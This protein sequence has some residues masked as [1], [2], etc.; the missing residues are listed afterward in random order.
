MSVKENLIDI[1]RKTE[2]NQINGHSVLAE[3][4]FM[5]RVFEKFADRLLSHGVVLFDDWSKTLD[6]IE[7][8]CCKNCKHFEEDP[9]MQGYYLCLRQRAR[10]VYP[11]EFCSKWERRT[12]ATGR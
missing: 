2:I 6:A 9:Y 12:D 5:P 3:V 8:V 7:P 10:R 4:C 1:L 11:Q